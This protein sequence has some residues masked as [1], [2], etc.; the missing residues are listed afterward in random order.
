M[1]EGNFWGRTI[2]AAGG[3]DDPIR[4]TGFGPFTPGFPLVEYDNVPKLEALVKKDKNV[5]AI[6]VE[7]I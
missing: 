1:A 3:S 2:T 4:Y 6:M 5:A 7:P